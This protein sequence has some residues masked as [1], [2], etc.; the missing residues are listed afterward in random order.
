MDS[1]LRYLHEVSFIWQTEHSVDK[2][3]LMLSNYF[4]VITEMRIY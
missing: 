1:C 2:M 3:V 4:G